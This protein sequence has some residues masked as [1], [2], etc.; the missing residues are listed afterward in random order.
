MLLSLK[1]SNKTLFFFSGTLKTGAS[2]L[3]KIS[4][5]NSFVNSS[6][7][8]NGSLYASLSASTDKTGSSNIFVFS[9]SKENADLLG[10]ACIL[11]S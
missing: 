11:F 6:S 9:G 1:S 7:L 5:A 4:L 2:S 10:E 8:N 3:G